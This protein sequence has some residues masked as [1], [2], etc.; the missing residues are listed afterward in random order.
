MEKLYISEMSSFD[1]WKKLHQRQLPYILGISGSVFL[2]GI[3]IHLV[4]LG[5]ES[6]RIYADEVVFYT[7]LLLLPLAA[8][9]GLFF[10]E[11]FLRNS[12]TSD[13][14]MIIVKLLAVTLSVMLMSLLLESI[15]AAFGYQDDDY[16]FLGDYQMSAFMTNVVE[17]TFS[18]FF[19]ALP[20]FIWKLRIKEL[21]SKLKEREVEEERLMRLKTQA[22]LQALQSR[23]N[24]HF[25][26]NAFNSIANLISIDPTAAEKM[27]VQLSEL[28][29]YSLNSQESNFIPLSEEIRIV[30]IYLEIEKVR[31]GENLNYEICVNENLKST[32]IPRFLIQPLVENAVKY[33]ML[34]MKKVHIRLEVREFEGQ[35]HMNVFDNGP[36]FPDPMKFGYGLQST[37]DKLK[38]LYP[39][40]HKVEFINAPEKQLKIN[41]SSKSKYK[42]HVQNSDYRR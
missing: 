24:P 26:F 40:N 2:L 41:F 37:Y 3:I 9:N 15:Y 32:L 23:I 1:E 25:L 4:S 29:R 8:I 27:M 11:R 17:Y 20:I 28:F 19:I 12:I 34:K 31:F 36:A 21:S 13:R 33:T 38:L 30:E 7:D 10:T 14:K 6:F 35:L 18:T 42:Q 22:E 16:I 39:D 5:I